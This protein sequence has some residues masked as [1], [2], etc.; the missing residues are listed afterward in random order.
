MMKFMGKDVK[1]VE[2]VDKETKNVYRTDHS[3]GNKDYN[4]ILDSKG[5]TAEVRKVVEDA[6]DSIMEE[7]FKF[8]ADEVKKSK[9][10]QRLVL[11]TGNDKLTITLKGESEVTVP[12][13]EV[14]GTPEKKTVYGQAS[15]SIAMSVPNVMK[16]S[17]LNDISSDIEKEFK[18]K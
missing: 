6:R 3:V 16:A 1:S 15:V 2:Q 18:K 17:I 7:G 12:A 14:G 11:G 8:L 4:S 13:R 9:V 5:V 10:D